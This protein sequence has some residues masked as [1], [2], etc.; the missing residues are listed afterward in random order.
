MGRAW[1]HWSTSR[2]KSEKISNALCNWSTIRKVSLA[3]LSR[4]ANE[5]C[6]LR[7]WSLC[8][9]RRGMIKVRR[10]ITLTKAQLLWDRLKRRR[11]QRY[12]LSLLRS[13]K[14]RSESC[15][16]KLGSKACQALS[17]HLWLRKIVSRFHQCLYRMGIDSSLASLL[18]S[19]IKS[20]MLSL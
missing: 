10:A 16:L 3:W 14:R 6:W 4:L 2:L 9:S 8:Y 13:W 19:K 5:S 18:T 20:S 17:C 12:R 7:T 15:R 11:S 1:K